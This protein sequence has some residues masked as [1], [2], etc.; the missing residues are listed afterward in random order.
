MLS[1]GTPVKVKY[2]SKNCKIAG[3]LH[4]E[5][6]YEQI[7]FKLK[8]TLGISPDSD[9]GE[10]HKAFRVVVVVAT[11]VLFTVKSTLE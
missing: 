6:V 11:I 7:A 5:E 3:R 2:T 1:S 9:L 4:P 10:L 8:L